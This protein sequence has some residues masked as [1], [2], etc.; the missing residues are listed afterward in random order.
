MRSKTEGFC[1]TISRDASLSSLSSPMARIKER[2]RFLANDSGGYPKLVTGPTE[3]LASVARK[4]TQEIDSNRSVRE[5]RV[6]R[7]AAIDVYIELTSVGDGEHLMIQ[8][9]M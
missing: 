7:A 6:V 1:R 9:G 2:L 3:F 4:A 8:L 5:C